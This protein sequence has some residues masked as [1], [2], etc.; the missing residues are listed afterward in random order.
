MVGLN[1]YF[2]DKTKTPNSKSC[3]GLQDYT[4]PIF[5]AVKD[6]KKHHFVIK[7]KKNF[8]NWKHF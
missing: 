6:L 3:D 2:I 8:W 4:M 7:G 1:C 5:K